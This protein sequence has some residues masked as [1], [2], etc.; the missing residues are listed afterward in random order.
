M[1]IY[2]SIYCIYAHIH[3]SYPKQTYCKTRES[4]SDYSTGFSYVCWLF[5]DSWPVGGSCPMRIACTGTVRDRRGGKHVHDLLSLA[6]LWCGTWRRES[7]ATATHIHI[8]IN[9][10][11][12]IVTIQF[13]LSLLSLL[14]RNILWDMDVLNFDASI[15]H[16]GQG[17]Q[18]E[19][20]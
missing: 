9:V 15:R 20:Q 16:W 3:I 8:Y 6:F 1:Y 2:M 18:L 5:F 14:S 10:V 4:V 12:I 11:I 7:C 13:W 17:S 19:Q